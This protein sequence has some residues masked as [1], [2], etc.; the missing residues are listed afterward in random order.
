[1]SAAT[2]GPAAALTS[3]VGGEHVATDADTLTR[4]ARDRL[5]FGIFK[6]RSGSLPGVMPVAVV[7]PAD[8]AE[9]VQLVERSARDGFRIIPFGL[10]SGVLGGTIPLGEEV[11]LDITRLDRMVK[12]DELNGLATVQAGMNGGG[13]EKALN[14]AGWTSGHL[15]QSIHIST[16]GGWAACRGGGQASRATARSR[17]SWSVCGPSCRMG[18]CSTCGPSRAAPSVRR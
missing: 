5:P 18:A 6:A 12:I 13:F 2:T 16:V 14:D 8:E 17:T 11:M 1:M 4:Y 10:G 9:V 3:I 7:K 15:P